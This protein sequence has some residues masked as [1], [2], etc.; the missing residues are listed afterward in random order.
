MPSDLYDAARIDG[1]SVPGI[2]WRIYVPLAKNII[3][4]FGIITALT[5]WNMFLWPLIVTSKD[6]MK[7]LTLVLAALTSVRLLFPMGIV[8][9]ASFLSM[10]PVLLVYI[11][12]QRWFIEGIATTGMKY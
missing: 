5:A 10:I 1:C 11:F 3:S 4:A 6:E 2:F 7:V 9:A 8:L 12:A